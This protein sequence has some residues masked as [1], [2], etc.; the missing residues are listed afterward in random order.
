MLSL[1]VISQSRV[2]PARLARVDDRF[3]QL[4]PDAGSA[5]VGREHDELGLIVDEVEQRAADRPPV[6]LDGEAV[7][8]GSVLDQLAVRDDAHRSEVR[9][10]EL[11]DPLTVGGGDRSDVHLLPSCLTRRR[12]PPSAAAISA[13]VQPSRSRSTQSLSW[14]SVGPAWSYPAGASDMRKPLRS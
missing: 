14:P 9:D 4:R 10:D 5:V 12:R 7:E 3:E 13:S 6:V 8:Q 2:Q 11:G 1:L